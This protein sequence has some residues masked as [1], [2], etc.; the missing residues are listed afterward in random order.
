[1]RYLSI[2]YSECLADVG[3]TPLAR[4]VGSLYHNALADTAS[5]LFKTEVFRRRDGPWAHLVEF[6][7]LGWI[8]GFNHQRLFEPIGDIP[9]VEAEANFYDANAESRRRK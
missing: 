8:G 7:V 9:P 2:R 6:A 5:G 1:M 3:I 4:H